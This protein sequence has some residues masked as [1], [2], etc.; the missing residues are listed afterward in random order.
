MFTDSTPCIPTPN[1]LSLVVMKIWIRIGA[2]REG[3]RPPKQRIAPASTKV[4]F[5]RPFTLLALAREGSSCEGERPSRARLSRPRRI[6]RERFLQAGRAGRKRLFAALPDTQKA[7]P[8]TRKS[9]TNERF[10]AK[11]APTSNRFWV[12]N[13]SYRKQ[14][15]KPRLTGTRTAIWDFGFLAL[16]ARGPAPNFEQRQFRVTRP[17]LAQPTSQRTVS[18]TR[19]PREIERFYEGSCTTS[20]RNWPTNRSCRRQTIKPCLTETRT[21]SSDMRFLHH[22]LRQQDVRQSLRRRMLLLPGETATNGLH[23]TH[24]E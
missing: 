2:E 6:S 3:P 24:P 20:N 16:F 8:A 23:R 4:R 18:T 22:F 12:K 21:A 10:F 5:L 7:A 1:F 17:L 11:W 19:N 14:K 13:R 15:I 9:L